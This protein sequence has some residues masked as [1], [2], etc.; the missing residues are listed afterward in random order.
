MGNRFALLVAVALVCACKT[1]AETPA[2]SGPSD[3]ATGDSNVQD[4]NPMSDTG[5]GADTRDA[6]D[7]PATCAGPKCPVV[8]A[9][10]SDPSC[11]IAV[12]GTNVY[13]VHFAGSSWSIMRVPGAGGTPEYF[14]YSEFIVHEIAIQGSALYWTAS[15]AVYR[16][17]LAGARG[18][19]TKLASPSSNSSPIATDSA[20]VYW[21]GGSSNVIRKVPLMGGAAVDLAT[22]TDAL[23]VGSDGTNVYWSDFDMQG[24]AFVMVPVGGGTPTVLATDLSN[25]GSIAVDASG[26]YF[27]NTSNLF[28]TKFWK[29]PR[30]GGTPAMI[31]LSSNSEA[32]QIAVD[33]KDLYWAAY[34][35]I[36]KVPIGGGTI[37]TLATAQAG[38][39]YIGVDATNVYWMNT[40]DGTI[41]KLAK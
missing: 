1:T 18:S 38:A 16:R 7:G 35:T 4:V 26:V 13:W 21:T 17:D 25:P 15:D 34:R 36:A 24:G 9:T 5:M 11:C 10:D 20:A 29:V 30:G 14:E 32:Y 23:H 27:A 6:A 12:D 40:D 31:A 28:G 33:G 8:L 3:K 19:A 37:T 39:M 41:M 22:G 2:D